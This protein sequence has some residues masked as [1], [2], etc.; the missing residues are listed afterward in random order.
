MNHLHVSFKP[1]HGTN[2]TH[3]GSERGGLAWLNVVVLPLRAV[4]VAVALVLC[5]LCPGQALAATRVWAGAGLNNLTTNAAN[6]SG[7]VVPAA[8]DDLVFPSGV[9]MLAISNSFPVNTSF[10][11][12]RFTPNAGTSYSFSGNG[13]VIVD[14]IQVDSG[15]ATVFAPVTLGASANVLLNVLTSADLTISGPINGAVFASLNKIGQGRATLTGSNLYAGTTFVTAGTL[16]V[17]HSQALGSI[18]ANTIL[19]A[20]GVLEFD[21]ADATIAEPLSTFDGGIVLVTE[22]TTLTG[23]MTLGAGTLVYVNPAKILYVDG[24]ITGPGTFTKDGDGGMMLRNMQDNAFSVPGQPVVV[25]TGTLILAAVDTGAKGPPIPHVALPNGVVVGL[26]PSVATVSYRDNDQIEGPVVVNS[27]GTVDLQINSDTITSLNGVAGAVVNI[28]AGGRLTLASGAFAGDLIGAGDLAQE[29]AGQLLVLSGNNA[30]T[31]A[32]SVAGGTLQVD[33]VLPGSV[34]AGNGALCGA[35]TVGQVVMMNGTITAGTSA[36]PGVLHTQSITFPG[37]N[38]IFAVRALGTPAGRLY[39]TGTVTLTDVALHVDGAP[40]ATAVPGQ[41]IMLL[42]NDGSD[43]IVGTFTGLPE[44]ATV[45]V[46]GTPF[47]ISYTGGD[48]NDIVL[49]PTPMYYLSEGSTG[50]FFTTDI[51]LANPNATAAPIHVTFLTQQNGVVPKDLVLPAMSRTTLRLNDLPEIGDGTVSTIVTSL[52]G[53]P[54][55]VER[56][57]S[58]DKSGYGAHGEKASDGPAPTWYFAE[59][60]QGFFSTYVLL[61]NPQTTPNNATVTYLREGTTTLTRSYALAPQSRTTL[62]LG[63]DAGLV[64]QSF[65]MLVQ[66]D[67]PGIA[68]RAMY[69]GTNPLWSGGHES[70]GATHSSPTWLLAEGATGPFFETFILLANPNPTEAQVTVT[71][72]PAGGPP[73]TK[74]KTVPANGRLTI[75]IEGEDPALSNAAVGTQIQSSVPIIAERSQYWPDPAPQWYEAHNSFGVTAAGAKWGLAEGRVGQAPAY[76]TYILLANP[77]TTVAHVTIQFLREGG[78]ATIT[79]TFAVPA[80]SRLNVSV[81]PGTDV[82]ELVDENFGAILTSDQPIVVER[83]MYSNANGQI[84]AAGTNATATLLP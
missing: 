52:G 42:S 23:P 73:L 31:G 54:L 80:S 74:M 71:F 34:F 11:S 70:A 6:W 5:A 76:Q 35:G 32:T 33:G 55:V 16:R 18:G 3:R 68:E 49:V 4:A 79:K 36:T 60:S 82:P 10:H 20:A 9:L 56:T 21:L 8:G 72:L 43:P 61:A 7:G 2:H 13:I 41:P 1:A 27:G 78:G 24:R 66:F 26:G 40:G 38:D 29:G 15:G 64:G 59:G 63:A 46:N 19:F 77:G 53:L 51:L 25:K 12:L 50:G 22:T 58:W 44:G 30:F 65:G 81:G 28:W 67:Q 84:W 45:T 75:N 14:H 39:V 57:M 69:F 47:R 48:G 62:D 37:S 83:S 17:Q